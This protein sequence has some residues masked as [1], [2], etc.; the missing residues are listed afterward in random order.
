MTDH[1]EAMP[2]ALALLHQDYAVRLPG[3][4]ADIEA[5]WN[6]IAAGEAPAN[7]LFEVVRATHSLAGS[8][9]I[10]GWPAVGEA[11]RAVEELLAP[12]LSSASQ[13]GPEEF[14]RGTELMTLLR[15]S[16]SNR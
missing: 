11:A 12:L 5:L 6:R 16:A 15:N 10:F 7:A 14:A 3:K 4:L 8:A 2:E 1:S 9:S 13:P